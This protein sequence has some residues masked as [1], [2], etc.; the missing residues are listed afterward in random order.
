MI[1]TQLLWKVNR[2]SDVFYQPVTLPII[3]SDP[4]YP[5]LPQA[6]LL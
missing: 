6:P 4:N 3:L 5:K 1:G 2:K